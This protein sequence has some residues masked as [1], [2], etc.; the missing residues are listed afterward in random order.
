MSDNDNDDDKDDD[1]Y[2]YEYH[3]SDEEDHG[4]EHEMKWNHSSIT[5]IALENPN[6]A[7]TD[8]VSRKLLPDSRNTLLSSTTRSNCFFRTVL[9]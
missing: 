9:F 1:D 3:Y 2:S 6:A 7:P 5:E 8:T 4:F